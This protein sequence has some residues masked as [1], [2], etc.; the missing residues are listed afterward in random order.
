M[1]IAENRG[2]NNERGVGW[3]RIILAKQI[4]LKYVF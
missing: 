4:T 1:G 3:I 2:E